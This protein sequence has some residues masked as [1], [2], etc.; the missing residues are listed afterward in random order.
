MMG[1]GLA[2]EIN[3]WADLFEVPSLYLGRYSL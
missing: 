2:Y 1:G 3:L